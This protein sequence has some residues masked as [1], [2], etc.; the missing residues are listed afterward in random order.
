MV[1]LIPGITVVV[2]PI[3]PVAH[4]SV[5]EGWRWA[6]MAGVGTPPAD[7]G[8]CAN[9]GWAPTEAEAWLEGETVGAA[10]TKALR[11]FG[12]PATYSKLPL[13]FDP[14]PAGGDRLGTPV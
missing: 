14:I 12:V 2:H 13:D 4:P 8:H 10:A 6:V 11:M 9:A 7:L 3:D 5:P 1:H